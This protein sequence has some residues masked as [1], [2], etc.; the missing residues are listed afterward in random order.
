MYNYYGLIVGMFFFLV[1]RNYCRIPSSQR[2]IAGEIFQEESNVIRC[3]DSNRS[4]DPPDQA[5]LPKA[6]RDIRTLSTFVARDIRGS[7]QT[8]EISCFPCSA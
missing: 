2:H 4:P 7:G 8:L 3:C 6:E 1:N 5:S